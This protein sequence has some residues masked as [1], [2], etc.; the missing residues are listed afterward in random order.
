MPGI[1][2]FAL[3]FITQIDTA[4]VWWKVLVDEH[5]SGN[6]PAPDEWPPHERANGRRCDEDGVCKWPSIKRRTE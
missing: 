3:I 5:R 4:A 6:S 2:V 1:N